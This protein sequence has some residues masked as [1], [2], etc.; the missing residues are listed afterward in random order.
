MVYKAL[1]LYGSL[2]INSI[3]VFF[4]LKFT[5]GVSLENFRSHSC[6]SV[7]HLQSLNLLPVSPLN[8][9]GKFVK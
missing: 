1:P 6:W 7:I 4:L 8:V 5:L 3:A 2:K 9:F